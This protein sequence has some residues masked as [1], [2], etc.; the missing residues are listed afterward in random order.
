[1]GRYVPLDRSPVRR[2]R[3]PMPRISFEKGYQSSDWEARQRRVEFARR[4]AVRR[5]EGLERRFARLPEARTYRDAVRQLRQLPPH[6]G[7]PPTSVTLRP[8]LI[9]LRG[10][11]V[12]PEH[13][14]SSGTEGWGE[15]LAE[16]HEADR[17]SRP[18]AAQLVRSR[19]GLPLLLTAYY[20]GHVV[21]R[22]GSAPENQIE[23]LSGEPNW[24]VLVGLS[25]VRRPARRKRL[26]RALTE[27]EKAGL[28]GLGDEGSHNRYEGFALL[29]EG[30]SD[31]K[32]YT[33][34]GEGSGISLPA[35]FWWNGWH[36]ALEPGE[37]LTLLMLAELAAFHNE[38]HEQ[39]GVGAP[40]TVRWG[41]YGV[42]GE[43][44]DHH[45]FLTSLGLLER[46]Q[47]T[48]ENRREGKVDVKSHGR[49]DEV[50]RF[51]VRLDRLSEPQ[52]HDAL[53]MVSRV[54]KSEIDL[55]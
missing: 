38:V 29:S 49:P 48:N 16:F 25:H 26:V 1:M 47:D 55:L 32:A 33:V 50:Y 37:M 2:A 28:V 17:E 39:Q 35:E 11:R 52:H 51:K 9:R 24:S 21:T 20:V 18:P 27:L 3:F 5:R 23:L 6:G 42:S 54:L 30:R 14:P 43:V 15:A 22:P 45:R 36:L 53:P 8:P 12:R 34:P 4:A 19:L 40:E 31:D 46:V 41:K 13:F 44:Y 10:L 7:H